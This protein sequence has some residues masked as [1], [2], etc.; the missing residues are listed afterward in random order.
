MTSKLASRLAAL[1][2]VGTKIDNPQQRLSVVCWLLH[3]YDAHLHS[4]LTAD[5]EMTAKALQ[6][7]GMSAAALEVRILRAVLLSQSPS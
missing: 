4:G 2:Y 1:G 6:S 3:K 7:L 5:T